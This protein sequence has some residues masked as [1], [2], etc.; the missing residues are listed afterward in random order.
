MIIAQV[1]GDLRIGGAERLFVNLANS[2]E[3]ETVVILTGQGAIQRDL[4]ESLDSR[5]K[6]Y[7][8]PVRKRLLVPDLI[9]LARLFRKLR[10]N[11]VHTHMFWANLYGSVAAALAAVPVTITSEHGRN[12]WK[13]RRHRWLESR[14]ISRSAKRRLCVSQDILDRRRDVDGIPA[15]KLEVSPNGTS[16]PELDHGG[17]SRELVIGSVGRL[18]K[19]KDFPTL[20][21]AVSRLAQAGYE[22]RLEI[23]GGGPAR[24]AIESAIRANQAQDFVSLVGVQQD[25]G[26]WLRRWSIFAS[27][28]IQEGQPIALLEAMA[29]E[30]PCVATAVGGVPDTLA[31]GSEGLIVQ[32][33]HADA[34][35]RALQEMIDNEKLR[36]KLG[37][38][39]RQ[40]VIRDFSI[41][42]LAGR[43]LEIYQMELEVQGN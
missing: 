34:L 7:E 21:E 22:W 31:D 43:C 8:S 17:N 13:K 15:S 28:S 27:S 18:V 33:G 25:V 37:T 38:A 30:L 24:E 10:C 16:I 11:V 14:V 32:P 26:R 20:V 2:L 39:A 12:E 3:A 42:A 9:R 41:G 35:F 19:E 29:Y 6:V 36:N 23:V 1:I 5:I 40:R 4:Q